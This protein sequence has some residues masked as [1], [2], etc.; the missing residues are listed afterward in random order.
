MKSHPNERHLGLC[1][2]C[3]TLCQS[4][5]PAGF[6]SGNISFTPWGK[7]SV[8]HRILDGQIQPNASTCQPVNMC[9]ECMA[10]REACDHLVDVP[11]S[12]AS[13]RND[14]TQNGALVNP[15]E[16]ARFDS[17][18]AWELLQSVTPTWRQV[19]E[20]Q[21]LLVPGQELLQPD[22][23]HIL[24]SIFVLL[25]LVGDRTVGV[26]KDSLLECGHAHYHHG[27]RT[28]AISEAKSSFRRFGRYS[29]VILVSPH[30]MA[31]VK[32]QWPLLDMDRSRI[33]TSLL[34]YVGKRVDFSG[35]GF[36]GKRVAWHD[37]CHL[38]RHLGLYQL[39]R[40]L[41]TWA[42]NRP[43]IELAHHQQRSQCC[44]GGY[45][46]VSADPALSLRIS[47]LVLDEFR[48][49]GAEQ[50]ITGCGQCVRQLKS[51]DPD[52]PVAHLFEVL[53]TLGR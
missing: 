13:F 6:V 50:L 44:G 53:A 3:P 26:N 40:D 29:K 27:A 4:R 5:C 47:Q 2:Y 34:E 7:M 8:A 45:P 12:L 30:C 46:L 39:P 10:C 28:T 48:H 38:G 42:C 1:F 22:S 51:A 35:A 43:P 21:V 11:A 19:E 25:D 33:V 20:T 49:S 24:R 41:L 32:L 31:F 16:S 14:F 23:V 18:K 37:P 17:D 36:Y 9:L 52:A 15:V